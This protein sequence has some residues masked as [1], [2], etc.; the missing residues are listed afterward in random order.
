MSAGDNLSDQLNP[1]QFNGQPWPE[2]SP[3]GQAILNRNNPEHPDY[4][5]HDKNTWHEDNFEEPKSRK[6]S[7]VSVHT[8][9]S[10]GQAYNESQTNE[11]IKDGDVLSVPSEGVHGY[12]HQ[13]WPIA[14]H[15]RGNPGEFHT[16]KADE[17][18]DTSESL[19]HM[20]AESPKYRTAH[21][22]AGKIAGRS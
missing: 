10:T 6:V 13:A 9:S 18:G 19:S 7:G 16:P 3:T 12:L 2:P 5:D 21:D 14:T 20:L 1:Q 11:R 8:F 22:V 17:R 4:N 15:H